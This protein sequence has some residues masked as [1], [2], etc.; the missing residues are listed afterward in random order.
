MDQSS[1]LF[2]AA[3]SEASRRPTPCGSVAQEAPDRARGPRSVLHAGCVVPVGDD[4]GPDPRPGLPSA[5]KP[6]RKGI[7][8]VHGEVEHIDPA[9]AGGGGERRKLAPITSSSPS[10]PSSRWIAVPGLAAAGHTFCTLEGAVGPPERAPGL[11][12][13][14]VVLLTAAPAYKCPA[15]PY[16]AAMLIDADCRR[17]GLRKRPNIPL[18]GGARPDGRRRAGRI[19]GGASHGRGEGRRVP[20]RAPDRARGG[21]RAIFTNGVEA[22][23]DLLAYVPPLRPQRSSPTPVSS[24]AP[25]G[26][27][28]NGTPW[29]PRSPASMPSVT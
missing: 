2:S 9:S 3:A 26:C 8:V 29:K 27:A 16:E 17:R 11:P 7:E 12:G 24:M 23:F 10:A 18:L 5:R 13:R 1:V 14:A 19:G 4:R 6:P 15:A 28:S 20:P 22:D 25:A 21:T